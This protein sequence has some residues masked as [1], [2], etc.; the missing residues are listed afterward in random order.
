MKCKR[1]VV[2]SMIIG[3]SPSGTLAISPGASADDSLI[4]GIDTCAV[5][6]AVIPSTIVLTS[7]RPVEDSMTLLFIINIFAHV[8]ALIGPVEFAM[9]VHFVVLPVSLVDSAV[10][11]LVLACT[12]DVVFFKIAVV[13][14]LVG[15]SELTESMLLTVSIISV[16]GCTIWPGLNTFTVLL[17]FLPLPSVLSSI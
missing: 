7:I 2:K 8:F 14:A 11:P 6:L 12:F 4:V 10:S 15:P 13:F 3:V 1:R 5:L 17:V 9:A 16:I